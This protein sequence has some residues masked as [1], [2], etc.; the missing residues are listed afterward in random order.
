M[1]LFDRSSFC[2]C[3]HMIFLSLVVLPFFSLN[4]PFHFAKKSDLHCKHS[5]CNSWPSVNRET[6]CL[7]GHPNSNPVALASSDRE[8][9]RERF[10]PEFTQILPN[11]V[12]IQ[13]ISTQ[14]YNL[15]FQQSLDTRPCHCLLSELLSSSGA[16]KNRS[17]SA[18]FISSVCGC[19]HACV[20][21]L[22]ASPRIL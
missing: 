1:C 3:F 8:R 10:C 7:A 12:Q 5:L 21:V 16:I 4:S 6:G 17:K 13:T 11:E 22:P 14:P 19:V 18:V 2:L 9:K 15:S 20:R